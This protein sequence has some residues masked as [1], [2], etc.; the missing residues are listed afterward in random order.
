MNAALEVVCALRQIGYAKRAGL[1]DAR[2][3]N[4]NICESA[5]AFGNDG[6]AWR[7]ETVNKP[8]AKVSHL[9]E[10]VRLA[11]LINNAYFRA[12]VDLESVRFKIPAG[13]GLAARCFRKRIRNRSGGPDGDVA[14]EIRPQQRVERG[15][16]ALI[17]R[18]NLRKLSC[19]LL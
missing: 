8:A 17:Q 12:L 16:I 5:A 10:S 13:V 2:P 11:S 3:G 15:W 4:R 19:I 9:R 1:K 14:A 7:V 6:F 18:H